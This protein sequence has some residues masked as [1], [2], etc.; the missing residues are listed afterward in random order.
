MAMEFCEIDYCTDTPDCSL[1][2]ET[3]E[4]FWVLEFC[5]RHAAAIEERLALDLGLMRHQVNLREN[6]LAGEI[7][8]LVVAMERVDFDAMIE[9]MSSRA[10]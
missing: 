9:A 7:G 8:D 2:V 1:K 10:G 6:K 3:T 4:G 5:K